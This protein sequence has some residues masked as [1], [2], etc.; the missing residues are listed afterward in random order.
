VREY[1]AR[2]ADFSGLSSEREQIFTRLL[3]QARADGVEVLA[4]IPPLHADLISK[5]D[6]STVRE[7]IAD[8][9]DLLSKLDRKGLLVFRDTRELAS[10]G[11]DP[12]GYLD[13]AHMDEAN[14]ARLASVAFLKRRQHALQ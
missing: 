12:S 14:S 5:L 9:A 2:F 4:V 13:G 6:G 10:F 8:T 7:R 11:G 1:R 3:E